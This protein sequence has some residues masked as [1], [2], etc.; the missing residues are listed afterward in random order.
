VNAFNTDTSSLA[1]DPPVGLVPRGTIVVLGGRGESAEVY[2]RFGTRLAAD[3]Y[4]VRVLTEDEV[5]VESVGQLFAASDVS[6]RVLAGSD[7]GA[8]RVLSFAKPPDLRLDGVILAGTPTSE[9]TPASQ[10]WDAELDA[11]TA[12]PVH[13]GRL[14]NEEIVRPGALGERIP[15]ALFQEAVARDVTVPVLV[16]H[17]D[18]DPIS[19][20]QDVRTWLSDVAHAEFVTV[21]DGHHDVLNDASHRSVAA[22]IVLWLERLRGAP[23]LVDA[24]FLVRRPA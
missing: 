24:P 6:P 1:I 16:I 4:R 9:A 7:T 5:D 11:R 19:H 23:T 15:A 8:L 10:H 2:R 22:A 17:G 18:S 3:A 14:S 13:R 21:G 12:C 20:E